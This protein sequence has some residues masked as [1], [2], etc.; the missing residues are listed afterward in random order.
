MW[1]RWRTRDGSAYGEGDVGEL[2]AGAGARGLGGPVL[3][4]VEPV[5]GAARD[6]VVEDYVA[7]VARAKVTLDHER[8]VASVGV[9]IAIEDILN[10]GAV[11]QA[12]NRATARLVAPNWKALSTSI[13]TKVVLKDLLRST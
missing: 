6:E 10:G 3:V 7:N 1:E 8:L 12:A 5:R 4:D 11:R 9:H 13:N 2:H